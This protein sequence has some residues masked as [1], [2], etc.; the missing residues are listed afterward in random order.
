MSLTDIVSGMNLTIY[1]LVA[2]VISLVTF[3]GVVVYA[4]LRPRRE[5]DRQAR[6]P[7]EDDDR[8]C[9]AAAPR[10]TVNRSL[11]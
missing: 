6:L 3:L 8:P 2:L 5:I 7:L 11:P 9:R 4:V 10:R 1:P